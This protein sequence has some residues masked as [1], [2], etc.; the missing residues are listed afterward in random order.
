[1]KRNRID[2]LNEGKKEANVKKQGVTGEK[3]GR[4]GQQKNKDLRG[5]SKQRKD[6]IQIGHSQN[7]TKKI[8]HHFSFF[9]NYTLSQFVLCQLLVFWY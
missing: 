2:C 1:M 6:L 8:I 9:S 5:G 3:K 4:N 7:V